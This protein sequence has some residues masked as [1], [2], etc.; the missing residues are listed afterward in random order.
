MKFRSLAAKCK[1]VGLL[2]MLVAF[3]TSVSGDVKAGSTV[4]PKGAEVY[5]IS[6]ADGDRVPA[7]FVVRFGLRGMGVAP[8]GVE[9]TGTGHHHLMIN[10]DDISLDDPI[11]ADEAHRHFGGGQSEVTLTLKPGR[12]RL[13]LVLGD[14]NHIPHNPPVMSD[15]ITVIVE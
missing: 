6:P 5:F 2:L 3:M 7:S 8:A 14:H 13:R 1:P 4:S 15:E 11:M 9:K 12:H 10:V